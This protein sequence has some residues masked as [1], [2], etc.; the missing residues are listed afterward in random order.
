MEKELVIE[1]CVHGCY[2]CNNIW[3]AAVRKELLSEC[4]VRNMKNGYA[5]RT[6]FSW[7]YFTCEYSEISCHE[8]LRY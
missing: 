1:L 5:I 8:R 3:E 6:S 4:K 7:S 2:V